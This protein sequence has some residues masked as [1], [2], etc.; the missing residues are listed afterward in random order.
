[1]PIALAKLSKTTLIN[2]GAQVQAEQHD[3]DSE[4]TGSKVSEDVP[5]LIPDT[6]SKSESI[7][8]R[9][10]RIIEEVDEDTDDAECDPD[11]TDDGNEETKSEGIEELEK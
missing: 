10:G 1:M 7:S 9:Q 3:E 8:S 5:E 4:D 6:R 11:D 2:T